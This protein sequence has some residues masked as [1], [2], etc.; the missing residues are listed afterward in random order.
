MTIV[1]FLYR[2]RQ[3]H[4]SL[5]SYGGLIPISLCLHAYNLPLH[6]PSLPTPIQNT[7]KQG[8][9]SPSH[10]Q[11]IWNQAEEVVGDHVRAH[12][13]TYMSGRC[14]HSHTKL[15][16]QEWRVCTPTT[17]A[18]GVVHAHRR[19]CHLHGTI[20]PPLAHTHPRQSTK[21]EKLG[22]AAFKHTFPHERCCKNR[23]PFGRNSCTSQTSLEAKR[24]IQSAIR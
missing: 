1:A 15:H 4:R 17:S 22:A 21:L 11:S 14:M 20:P 8:S 7:F 9:Q 16:L 10:S 5:A 13:S 19:T 12:S 2:Y 18:N 23:I 6:S 24:G 3:K